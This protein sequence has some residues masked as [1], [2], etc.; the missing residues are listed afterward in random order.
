MV[1][2]RLARGGCKKH[3]H[4]SVVVAPSRNARNGRFIEKIGHYDPFGPTDQQAVLDILRYDY[5]VSKGA[6]ASDRVKSLYHKHDT[7]KS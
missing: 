6:Q 5:W 4:Y 1:K 2:I 7:A 3:P